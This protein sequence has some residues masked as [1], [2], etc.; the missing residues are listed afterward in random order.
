VA[1]LL[2]RPDLEAMVWYGFLAPKGTAPDIL[3]RLYAEIEKAAATPRVREAMDRNGAEPVSVPPRE[4][5]QQIRNDADSS[6]QL[7]KAL[8]LTVE[9]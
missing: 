7:L 5:Y 3:N 9:K 6:R 1:E 4:F 2:K 8:G